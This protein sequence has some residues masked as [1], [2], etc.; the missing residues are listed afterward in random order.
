MRRRS[1][2]RAETEELS[3]LLELLQQLAGAPVTLTGLSDGE[4]RDR[5]AAALE[6]LEH[7]EH[8]AAAHRDADARVPA[9]G[10]HGRVTA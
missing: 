3:A 10:P 1:L 4:L 8:V 2:L 7:A 5:A 6:H 9:K